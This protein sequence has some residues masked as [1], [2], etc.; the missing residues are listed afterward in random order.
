MLLLYLEKNEINFKQKE[1]TFL[2]YLAVSGTETQYR[3]LKLL[4]KCKLQVFFF[5]FF[6]KYNFVKLFSV[7]IVAVNF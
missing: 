5:L 7:F 2:H 3:M 1:H 4:D 6:F